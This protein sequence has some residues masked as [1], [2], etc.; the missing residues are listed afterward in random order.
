MP[1]SPEQIATVG[2]HAT[3]TAALQGEDDVSAERV[4]HSARELSRG[5]SVRANAGSSVT[6]D[7]LVLP[8]AALGEVQR[9]LDWARY[10]DE[11]A[12]MGPLHG[13]GG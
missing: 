1:L 7:D 8:P 4:R 5:R 10:R 12:A 11:V 6:L 9:L 3:T 13:K 2:R